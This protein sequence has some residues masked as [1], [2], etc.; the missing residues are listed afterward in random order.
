MRARVDRQPLVPRS[1][2]LLRAIVSAHWDPRHERFSSN[3]FRDPHTSVSSLSATNLGAI[4]KHFHEQLTRSRRH[5]VLWVGQIAYVR[6][7]QLG[8][9]TTHNHQRKPVRLTVRSAPEQ[10]N[11]AHAEIQQKIPKG[12]SLRISQALY[13]YRAEGPA[14][15]Y[16]ALQDP[17]SILQRLS[18]G[19]ARRRA[20]KL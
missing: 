2:K 11:S 6:L 8:W 10:D 18:F 19:R 15:A 3:L 13:V 4:V 1:S 16:H 5:K 12:L 17:S 9:Q 7:R 20:R 14:V